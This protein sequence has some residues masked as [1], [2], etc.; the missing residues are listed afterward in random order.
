[1][2]ISSTFL[3]TASRL[4]EAGSCIGGYS[5][6]VCASF[7]TYCWTSDEA[8]ELAGEE[9]VASSRTR[10]CS[11]NSPRIAW[12]ALERVLANVDHEGMSVVDFSPGQ[13]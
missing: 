11:S 7:P 6:A 1:M 9:V 4:N 2:I 12:R 10:Q 13:P 8:P 5:I 3:F